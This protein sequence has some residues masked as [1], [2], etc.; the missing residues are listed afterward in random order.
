MGRCE[1]LQK[2]LFFLIS[3]AR[4]IPVG[5]EMGLTFGNQCRG[6]L[7][8]RGGNN[9]RIKIFRKASEGWLVI[10]ERF[11]NLHGRYHGFA[12]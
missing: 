9:S 7:N 11:Q 12:D 1:G 6:E 4:F 10:E 8:M 3:N 2:F 5:E